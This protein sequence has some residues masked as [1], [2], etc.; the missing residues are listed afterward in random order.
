MK[1]FEEKTT[2]RYAE[3]DQMGIVHHSHYPVWFEAAR[4]G[5]I[6]SL[7]MSYSE[8]EKKGLLLPLSELYVKYRS[9]ALYEDELTVSVHIEKLTGARVTFGYRVTRDKD[10]TLI[11]EG[12]TVHAF[13]DS[14]LCVV[15][16][17]K[18]HKEIYDML[19]RAWKD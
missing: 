19:Y 18:T 2:V 5:F 3:T 13:T 15:N 8:V 4:T 9:G 12:F 17:M 6:K 16:V 14:N 10:C 7:G 11:A 1:T